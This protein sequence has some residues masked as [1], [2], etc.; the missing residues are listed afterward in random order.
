MGRRTLHSQAKQGKAIGISAS[1]KPIKCISEMQGVRSLP[2]TLQQSWLSGK[3]WQGSCLTK[4]IY[5]ASLREGSRLPCS[6][7]SSVLASLTSAT[8]QVRSQASAR[9]PFLP[10]HPPRGLGLLLPARQGA[11]SAP[12]TPPPR[13]MAE[14]GLVQRSQLHGTRR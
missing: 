1:P 3:R 6:A 13:P 9:P 7:V 10:S 5:H 2:A 11:A 12:A 8:V 14:A 4:R